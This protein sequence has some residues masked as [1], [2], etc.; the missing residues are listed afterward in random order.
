VGKPSPSCSSLRPPA[1]R[2]DVDALGGYPV[3]LDQGALH[4]DYPPVTGEPR[5]CELE[6]A[7]A[8]LDAMHDIAIAISEGGALECTLELI[9]ERGCALVGAGSLAV[10]LRD[11]DDLVWG[12]SSGSLPAGIRGTRLPIAASA[13]GR[14]LE[15]RRP[16]RLV[17]LGARL[18]II[19]REDAIHEVHSALLLPMCHR[20]E[21]LGLLVRF[22]PHEPRRQLDAGDEQTLG[23]LAASAATAVALA[24]SAQTEGLRPSL[25]SAEHDRRR[26]AREL[27]DDALQALGGLR[28]VLREALHAHDPRVAQA[29]I[30]AAVAQ[31]EQETENLR[32]IACELHP[33][34]LDRSGSP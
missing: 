23:T 27:H 20:D 4:A 12:V 15:R 28:L 22:D 29:G 32:A 26:W 19:P 1:R 24:R 30:R 8:Q 33:T 6:R 2:A 18:G 16:E 9:V 10:M 3:S 17:E 11:G 5:R 34:A 21:A 25:L 13:Y 31:V 14:A 7:L